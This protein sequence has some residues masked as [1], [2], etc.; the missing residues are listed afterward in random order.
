LH[1]LREQESSDVG[2]RAFEILL[3]KERRFA[4]PDGGACGRT[5]DRA[6]EAF[7]EQA[8]ATRRSQ[9]VSADDVL[10]RIVEVQAGKHM[11]DHPTEGCR[12]SRKH[13]PEVQTSDHRIVHFEQQDRKSTRLNSS[14]EWISYAV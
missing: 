5:V 13:V 8:L 10:V 12:C 11:R 14:H 7:L 3:I 2:L 9:G 4:C 6:H 1:T